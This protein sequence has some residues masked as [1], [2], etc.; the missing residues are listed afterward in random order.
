MNIELGCLC[1]RC[2]NEIKQSIAK[3]NSGKKLIVDKASVSHNA[4]VVEIPYDNQRGG[5][6][7][8][9]EEAEVNYCCQCGQA[10]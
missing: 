8:V 2:I 6:N 3:D 5:Y 9:D 4:P 1:E 7:W 10:L